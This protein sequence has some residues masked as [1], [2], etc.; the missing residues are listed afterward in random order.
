MSKT[1]DAIVIGSGQGGNPLARA[2]AERGESIA[3][4]ESGPLGGTCIN[5]GCTPTKT[6]VASAQVAHYARNAARWGVNAGNVT[7]DLPA[8]LRRKNEVVARFRSGWENT[9]ANDSHTHLYRGRTRFSGRSQ[10]QINGE[11]ISGKRIFIDTGSVPTI[12]R[13]D[14]LD[15]VSYLTNVS[16]LE[17]DCLPEHLLVLGGGYV[18]LEFG[19]MFRRFGSK[20]TVIQS[21]ERILPR[22]DPDVTTEL[23]RCL[24]AEGVEFLLPARASKVRGGKGAVEL[25]V[26]TSNGTLTVS[27]SHL[28]VATGRTPQTKDL[29]LHNTG[30]EINSKGF[31]KVNDRLET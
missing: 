30:V 20:V 4:I 3:L 21:A 11:T 14:G 18:G 29:D 9:F 22:E 6:M 13:I 16:L 28:L 5:T 10:L 8:I 7:V 27:G 31:I 12:P 26:E 19:Q 24:E 15:T 1:Y 17:L 23:R 2:V 25:T